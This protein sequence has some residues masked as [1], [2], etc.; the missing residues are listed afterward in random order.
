MASQLTVKDYYDP[1]TGT[2]S[3]LVIDAKTNACVV[4]DPVL[5]YD[6]VSGHT[7]MEAVAPLIAEIQEYNRELIWILETHAHADHLTS[8]QQVKAACGG[9]VTIGTGIVGIQEKFKS[10]YGFDDSFDTSGRAFDRLLQDGDVL[11]FG[12]QTITVMATPGHTRDS[13]SFRIGDYIFI[14][15]TLFH[16]DIGT[17]RCD[18]P[19]GDAALLFQSINRILDCGD[20]CVLCLCHDYPGQDREPETFIPVARM[21]D[22]I[23]LKQADRVLEKFVEIRENRD[24]DLA[25]PKL[26]IPSIQVNCQ[27][28]LDDLEQDQ[29]LVWPINRF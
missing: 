6:M 20:H 26:I 9:Q 15:D 16:P 14:G 12:T 27:A 19:G 4:I 23:H 2:F 24:K 5:S 18:F 22:N 1:D 17:A 3:Y 7:S 21:R 25:L 11:K 28:G 8:A 10:V 29:H 13:L